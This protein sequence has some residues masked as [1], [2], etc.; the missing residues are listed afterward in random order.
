VAANVNA[1][2]ENLMITKTLH[3]L[4]LLHRN[5]REFY[6]RIASSIGSRWQAAGTAP[7]SYR[8]CFPERGLSQL[9]EVLH[10]NLSS[11]MHDPELDMLSSVVQGRARYT[12]AQGPFGAFHNG[13]SLLARVSYAIARALRPETVVETGVCYGVTSAHVLCALQH[14]QHGHMHSIDLPPLGNNGDAFVGSLVPPE[15]LHRWTLHRGSTRRLLAPLIATLGQIEIFLHDSQHTLENMRAE[16]LTV[17]PALRPGGVLIADDVE[18]N[19]AFQELA[20]RNDTALALVFREP[21]KGSLFGVAV[22]SS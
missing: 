6:E 17:W 4:S 1:M 12:V 16:F 3:L 13:G 21:S 2:R 5:P 11:I 14:N 18:S 8:V 20:R 19:S 15:L 22:K 10:A 7:P 9:S